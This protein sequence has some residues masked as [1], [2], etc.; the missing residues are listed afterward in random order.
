MLTFV[1]A[2]VLAMFVASIRLPQVEGTAL[3]KVLATLF[4]LNAAACACYMVGAFAGVAVAGFRASA[5][6]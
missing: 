3:A 6:L 5:G 1:A 2:L 4:F